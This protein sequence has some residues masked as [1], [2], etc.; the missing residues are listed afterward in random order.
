ML[1]TGCYFSSIRFFYLFIGQSVS[2][3]GIDCEIVFLKGRIVH[4][5]DLDLEIQSYIFYVV[6]DVFKESGLGSKAKEIA[7]KRV[8]ASW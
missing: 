8:G 4:S 6:K 5:M 3:Q 2:L 1:D 7:P